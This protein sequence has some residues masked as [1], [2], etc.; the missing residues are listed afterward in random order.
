MPMPVIHLCVAKSLSELLAIQDKASFYLG[1]IAPDA[2]YRIPT[3]YDYDFDRMHERYIA[4]HLAEAEKDFDV[5]RKNVINFISSSDENRDFYTGYGVH[6]LTD[7]YWKETVFSSFLKKYS[8]LGKSYSES[9]VIY[10]SDAKIFDKD[11]YESFNLKSDVWGYLASCEGFGIGGLMASEDVQ[12]WKENTLK[13]FDS[14]ERK[15][16]TINY[17]TYEIV[18]NFINST[19]TKI[20]ESLLK[21]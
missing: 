16:N 13:L 4:A 14:E 10:Y 21:S 7:I 11:F 5:W 6:I 8:E 18:S 2:L 15:P 9:R 12:T 20:S 17:F 19:A 3:Y 1:S